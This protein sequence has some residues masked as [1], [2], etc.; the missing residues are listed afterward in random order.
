VSETQQTPTPGVDDGP[1]V[2]Q[3]VDA[4]RARGGTGAVPAG[5]DEIGQARTTR[6]ERRGGAA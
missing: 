4:R 6:R 5:D 3:L 1:T 2:E